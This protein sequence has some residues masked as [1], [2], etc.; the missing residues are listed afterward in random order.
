MR[1]A[2]TDPPGPGSVARS[3]GLGVCQALRLTRA[4]SQEGSQ[5]DHRA[6]GQL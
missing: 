4:P 2:L 6:R 3:K 1:N 5:A